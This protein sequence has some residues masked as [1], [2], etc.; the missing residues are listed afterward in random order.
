MR[1]S[2]SLLIAD[3]H[4]LFRDMLKQYLDQEKDMIVISQ[5][6]NAQAAVTQAIVLQ[7]DV[8]LLD[9]DMPGLSPFDAARTIKRK[10]P[11]TRILFLSAFIHDYYIA[12]ALAMEAAGYLTKHEPLD[13]LLH[14]IRR[15]AKGMVSFSKEVQSRIVVDIGGARLSHIPESRI[16]LLTKRE[17]QILG[18]IAHGLSKRKIAS[19]LNLSVK[20]VDQHCTHLM[21][22]LNIHDRVELTRFAIREGLV[23]A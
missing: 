17:I 1:K 3:D 21:E 8:I 12:Q 15:V 6:D 14:A 18:Y 7:P 11:E 16:S 2:I 23:E 19:T 10:C 13:S 22:K 5:V 20:T 4:T 9:I